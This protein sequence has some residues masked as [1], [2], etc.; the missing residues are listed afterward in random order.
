M[1]ETQR[2]ETAI[3]RA[4]GQYDISNEFELVCVKCT[5]FARSTDADVDA[6]TDRLILKGWR[7]TLGGMTCPRCK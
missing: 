4:N 7:R 2:V 3:A 1:I 6:A 5:R